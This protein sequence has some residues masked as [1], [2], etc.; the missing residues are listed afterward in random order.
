[1]RFHGIC[2]TIIINKTFSESGWDNTNRITSVRREIFQELLL[3]KHHLKP[4]YEHLIDAYCHK[5]L[6]YDIEEAEMWLKSIKEARKGWN[7][8]Q[9]GDSRDLQCQKEFMENWLVHGIQNSK[10]Y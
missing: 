8:T 6:S 9:H 7:E 10:K 1:M 5:G 4:E 3:N 2:G